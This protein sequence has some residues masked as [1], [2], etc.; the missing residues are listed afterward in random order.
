M[1]VMPLSKWQ[2][3]N[4]GVFSLSCLLQQRYLAIPLHLWKRVGNLSVYE[5]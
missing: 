1:A 5:S 4:K 2:H 3:S